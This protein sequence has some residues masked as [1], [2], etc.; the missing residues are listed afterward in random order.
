MDNVE[1]Y[2]QQLLD[3][4][5]KLYR[6]TPVSAATEN[7][8]L[9]TPRHCFVRRY[10]EWGT[11]EWREVT[12]D[13]LTEHLATLYANRPVILFGDDDQDIPSKRVKAGGG[14]SRMKL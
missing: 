13:N 9:A 14:I 1:K 7:A 12:P 2:Q 10:R 8:Y 11:R 6:E 4:T 3:Q 5:R